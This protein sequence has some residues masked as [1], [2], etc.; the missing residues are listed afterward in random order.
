MADLSICCLLYN[1]Q[2]TRAGTLE[3]FFNHLSELESVARVK[4]ERVVFVDDRTSDGT[5]DIARQHCNP[6]LFTFTDFSS[7]RNILLDSAKSEWVLMAEPDMRFNISAVVDVVKNRKRFRG[8]KCVEA[9]QCV[10]SPGEPFAKNLYYLLM[11]PSLR[12]HGIVFETTKAYPHE[13]VIL[14]TEIGDHFIRKREDRMRDYKG[15][16]D[17]EIHELMSKTET[18]DPIG[19][20]WRA[21]RYSEIGLIDCLPKEK[22]D[23]LVVSLLQRAIELK[24]DF[25]P[26]YFELARQHFYMGRKDIALATA[27]KGYEKSRYE[28]CLNFLR[29]VGQQPPVIILT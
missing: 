19:A 27:T 26:A 18:N 16:C 12:F 20:Y 4:A 1:S 14:S 2:I 11:S 8:Y 24:E 10:H 15:L 5:L 29:T 7:A 6:K 3:G 17:Q 22:M 9:F 28:S 21:M 13:R 25:G 23:L